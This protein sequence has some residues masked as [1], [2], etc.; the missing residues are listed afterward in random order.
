MTSI[1]T[2]ILTLLKFSSPG[3]IAIILVIIGAFNFQIPGLAKFVPL[4]A[5]MTIFYWC[6]YWPDLMPK[7]FVFLLGLFQDA[8]Y[9]TPIGITPL[10]LIIT[11]WV[12]VSGRK[13]LVKEPFIVIWLMFALVVTLYVISNWLL[14]S[15]YAGELLYSNTMW[16]Q[17]VLTIVIY[18]V[19][20]KLFNYI[21]ERL[22]KDN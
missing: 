10:L 15:I 13:H 14:N 1:W 18:P 2:K 5:L 19:I 7:W 22:L 8:I 9:G 20:H 17:C 4:F 12:I 16:M 3:Y 11:W 21:H 6:A